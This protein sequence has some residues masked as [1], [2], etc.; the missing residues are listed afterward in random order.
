MSRAN[1]PPLPL[2]LPVRESPIDPTEMFQHAA[3]LACEL[4][5]AGGDV[6]LTTAAITAEFQK[7]ANYAGEPGKFAASYSASVRKWRDAYDRN[8]DLRPKAAQWWTRD[9]VYSQAPPKARAKKEYGPQYL[10]DLGED[11]NVVR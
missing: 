5:P 9:G 8:H 10:G 6:S 1:D 11:E 4:L 2:P 7:S 3:K